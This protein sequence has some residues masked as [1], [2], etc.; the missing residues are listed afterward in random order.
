[1]VAL[2]PDRQGAMATLQRLRH[3]ATAQLRWRLEQQRQALGHRLFRLQELHPRAQL[4]IRK[5][6]LAQRRQLLT[7]LS[8]HHW[9]Q[10][11]FVLM[12]NRQGN[13]ISRIHQI[14]AGE[15]VS[16]QLV[17]GVL[18]A[19]ITASQPLCQGDDNTAPP[20]P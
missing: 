12:R 3:N 19:Q 15:S 13:L 20:G 18:E 6:D 16:L 2:L 7:A 11:G 14:E 1:M 8:P 9:L 4:Q 17:D 10:R 5:K